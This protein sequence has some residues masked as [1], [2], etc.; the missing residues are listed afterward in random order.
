[1]KGLSV[2]TAITV[3]A[4]QAVP[5][6]TEPLLH[7]DKQLLSPLQPGNFQA[8]PCFLFCTGIHAFLIPISGCSLKPAGVDMRHRQQSN[9]PR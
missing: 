6:V 8:T 7:M 4:T 2:I 3:E 9:K 1:M 5:L